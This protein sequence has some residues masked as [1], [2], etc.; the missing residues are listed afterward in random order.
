MELDQ[1][2]HQDDFIENKPLAEPSGPDLIL[3]LDFTGQNIGIP[4]V[5]LRAL[6]TKS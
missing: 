6:F 1:L 3:P 5:F 2:K 4:A